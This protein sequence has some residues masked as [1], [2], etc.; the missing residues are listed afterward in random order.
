[1][2]NT[3]KVLL[4]LHIEVADRLGQEPNKSAVVDALAAAHYGIT[5]ES[6]SSASSSRQNILDGF[7]SV[8]AVEAVEPISTP[9]VEDTNEIIVPEEVQFETIA[10]SEGVVQS[11]FQRV[12]VVDTNTGFE[13]VVQPLEAV[14]PTSEVQSAEPPTPEITVAEPEI[15]EEFVPTAYDPGS[16]VCPTCG[17][18][19]V[20]PICLTCL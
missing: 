10:P 14:E 12:D 1:M 15:I 5:F 13:P 11:D 16:R 6:G 17:E 2:A 8:P 7:K 3:R 19:M 18:I 4:S 9:I 20:T